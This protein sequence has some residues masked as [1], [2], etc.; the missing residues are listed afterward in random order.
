MKKTVCRIILHLAAAMLCCG[1]SYAYQW[2]HHNH[3]DGESLM[4]AAHPVFEENAPEGYKDAV[5]HFA[6]FG[7]KDMFYIGIGGSVKATMGVDWGAPTSNPNEF[8][9]SEIEEVPNGDKTKFNLSAMQSTLFVNFVAFP[10]SDNAIGAFFG[11]NLLNNYVPVMQYAYLKWRGIKA[12]YDY[13]VFSDNGAMPSTIDYEGPN[14]GTAFPVVTANYTYSFG[15]KKA[16]SVSAGVDLPNLSITNSRRSYAVNQAA[17]D[18]PL[19]IRY[20]WDKE[21]SWIKASAILRNMY[22]HSVVAAKNIDIVGWGVSLSGT[23]EIIPNLRG[24]WTAVYGHGIASK[25]QDLSG[26]NLDL[27]PRGNGTALKATKSWGAFGGLQYNFTDDIYCSAA[28]SHI[29]NYAEVW[30]NPESSDEQ[31]GEQYRYAQYAVG[32][33]FWDI[34]PIITTGLEY[35]YG[36]RVNNDGTQAHDNRLQCMLQV[37]F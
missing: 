36:R 12:G 8:I 37:S 30:I 23:S 21:N 9:T 15:K 29:R 6:I 2:H 5:P 14:A 11:M 27:T 10:N 24:F 34:S 28:Y 3:K 35:I 4:K 26:C 33:I 16:W 17:P 20:N 13:S 22:Y 7:K 1:E 25:I 31:Y 18:I 19:A 32:N